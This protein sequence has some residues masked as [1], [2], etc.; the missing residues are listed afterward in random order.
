MKLPEIAVRR[1]TTVVMAFLAV[2]LI[3]AV[4]VFRLSIDFF[5]EIEPP[6]ISILTLYRGANASDV[7]AD[8]TKYIED[9]MSV[10]NNLEDVTSLSKDNLSI[11]TL[12]FEWGSDLDVASNDVRDQLDMAKRDLPSDIEEPMLFKFS[13]SSAP[14]F[15]FVVNAKESYQQLY[16]IADDQIGDALRRIPGVGAVSVQG[17][18]ERQINIE[19]DTERLKAYSLSV[20]GISNTLRGE[21]VN[22]P[23]GELKLGRRTYQVRIPGRYKSV[24]EIA[25]AVVG[26]SGDALV[27]LRDVARVSD[28]FKESIQNAWGDGNAG[29]MMIVQKQTG[30]NTVEIIQKIRRELENLKAKLPPDVST[31][32]IIDSSSSITSSIRNLTY[33]AISGAILVILV[34]VVF[35][36]RWQ[37]SVIIILTIPFSIISAFIFLFLFDYTINVVSLL[38][39]TIATGMVVD[40]AI[41]ILE[42]ITRH[43]DAGERP[44][45]ASV[46]GSGEVGLAISAS[47]LT[48]VVVFMPLIF[49]GGI[50]GIIFKQLAAIIA[51]TLVASLVTSLSLTPMLSSRLLKRRDA[52]RGETIFNRVEDGYAH[53]LGWALNHR[54]TVVAVA[55]SLI[56]FC[57]GAVSLGMIGT[58]LFPRVDSGDLS[59]TAELPVDARLETTSKVVGRMMRL[60]EEHVPE[61]EHYYGMCGQSEMGIA[62]ALG[63]KEGRHVATGGVKLIAKE[64]RDRSAKEVANML[65]EKFSEIP[66]VEKLSVRATDPISAASSGTAGKAISIEILGYDFKQTTSL[67]RRIKEFVSQIPGAVDVTISR[68]AERP[69]LWVEV[70]R[71]K[72][73]SLG[74]S[75]AAIATT[76]RTNIFGGTAT[77]YRDAGDDYDIYL[78]LVEEERSS[79]EDIGEIT[80]ASV[81]GV[82]V[83]LKSVARIMRK[84][85][86]LEIERLNRQRVIKVE[87]DTYG[88][89][90]GEVTRDIRRGLAKL[91]IPPGITISFGGEVEEQGEAFRDL[92]LLL[93]LGIILVYMVMAS[94]FESLLDPFVIMFSVPFA[95]VGVVVAFL[96]TRMTLSLMSF[97]GI[98]MLMGIVVNNAIVMVDYINLLRG[99]GLELFEAIKKAAATRLRPVLMTTITT[100]FGILPMALTRGE[101]AEVYGPLG[102]TVIGGLMVSTLVTLVLVP[103]VYSIFETRLKT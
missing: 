58:E 65:R 86:P 9:R 53:L 100:L 7:E 59:V 11:V 29:A 96:V 26:R 24:D 82:P 92:T 84:S 70:D 21:N 4:A 45:V 73:A 67:A 63:F 95:F 61:V 20:D 90:L 14:I 79:I 78:R 30:T 35:L 38:S 51:I 56:L 15:F 28:D 49:V 42:N 85:G 62:S 80:I 99:R 23:V 93:L 5:P 46:V 8:V 50:S 87:A 27:Q 36:R 94:Q 103:V 2:L 13:S 83:K 55:I 81:T 52:A 10:V 88:R 54:K 68:S 17:G 57:I 48:T 89:S 31:T 3:G 47:T 33:A 102:V 60:I 98:I 97:I 44:S 64:K 32:I 19:F 101:G 34:S 43:V 12:K 22:L 74:L 1:P 75:M 66:G 18:L 72:A 25:S 39:I 69:E 71:R 91:D 40:N 41:V 37:S 76:L 16:Q 6:A 77:E